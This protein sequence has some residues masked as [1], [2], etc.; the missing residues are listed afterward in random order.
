MA[1]VA[2]AARWETL[3]YVSKDGW[4]VPESVEAVTNSQYVEIDGCIDT[5]SSKA[6]TQKF[7]LKFILTATFD[8]SG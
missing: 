4:C 5:A 1:T 7:T 6:Q 2:S 8:S 3:N